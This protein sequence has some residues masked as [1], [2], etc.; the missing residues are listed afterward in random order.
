MKASL[1]VPC[2]NAAPYLPRLSQ[3][4][5]RLTPSFGEILLV[6]DCSNDGTGDLAEQLGFT[7]IRLPENRGPGGARNVLAKACRGEWI[8]FLDADDL[9][10]P[11]FLAKVEPL[12][13]DNVDVVLSSADFIDENDHKLLRRWSFNA[14]RFLEDPVNAAFTNPVPLHCST[15]RRSMFLEIGGFDETKRCWEDG[16]LHLRLAAQGARFQVI[17]DVLSLSPRHSRGASASHLYCHKCRLEFVEQYLQ[18]KIPINHNSII[19]ELSDLGYLFLAAKQGRWA[20]RGYSVLESE[21]GARANSLNPLFDR[22]LSCLPVRTGHF[23]SAWSKLRMGAL[24][25]VKPC[26]KDA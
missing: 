9:I 25:R 15:I 7:V 12:L 4:V 1:L 8:H 3:E 26:G 22:L 11:E 16:D 24:Q 6:D 23:L 20:W 14:D 18:R 10:L 19:K 21:G 13:N 2:Y 5:Q 17:P